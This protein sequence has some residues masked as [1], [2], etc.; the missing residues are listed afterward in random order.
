MNAHIGEVHT[1]P[2]LPTPEKERAP[3]QVASSDLNLTPV[4]GEGREEPPSSQLVDPPSP[5]SLEKC[6]ICGET[7]IGKT[8]KRAFEI[9]H[10]HGS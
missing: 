6:D 7:F 2:V 3:D 10:A 5:G 4:L 8:L 9:P 1:A